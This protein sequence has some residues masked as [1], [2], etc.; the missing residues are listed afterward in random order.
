MGGP[1]SGRYP[2]RPGKITVD[3]ALSLDVRRWQRTGL[4]QPGQWFVAPWVNGSGLAPVTVEVEDSAVR[5]HLPVEVC[6]VAVELRSCLIQLETT[7]C[8]Y[9]GRRLWFSCP[10]PDCRRRAA[11]LYF[12]K[13]AFACR[14]CC[15][16]AYPTQ[17]ERVPDRALRRAQALRRRLGGSANLLAPFPAKPPRMH[18]RTYQ[19]LRSRAIAC[20]AMFFSEASARYGGR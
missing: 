15:G 20:E 10:T 8:N 4:M 17:H 18:W 16:L 3:L 11:L 13:V 12:A 6:G 7:P 5:L 14:V 9:G 19:A 2:R 1:G